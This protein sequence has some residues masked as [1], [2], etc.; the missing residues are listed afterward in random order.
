MDK[1]TKRFLLGCGLAVLVTMFVCGTI[2][3]TAY[4]TEGTIISANGNP[5]PKD[6]R[7]FASA[8]TG[9]LSA[10]VSIPSQGTKI[11]EVAWF[12]LSLGAPGSNT[13]TAKR[14]SVNGS[15]Y[16]ATVVSQNMSSET[17]VFQV[18]TPGEMM[19]DNGDTLD[20]DWTNASSIQW[21]LEVYHKGR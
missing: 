21:T 9:N 4:A 11:W 14:N 18:Y 15:T 3:A 2:I 20:F 16:D 19:L 17:G 6:I 5:A 7:I 8:G 12:N 1:D 13:F 10:S